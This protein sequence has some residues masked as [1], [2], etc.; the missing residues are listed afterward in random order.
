MT[1]IIEVDARKRVSLGGLATAERYIA[2]VDD[3]GVITL[4]PAVVMTEM[5]ARLLARPDILAAVE[6]SRASAEDAGRPQRRQT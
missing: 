1:V 4:S 6:K 2:D 3:S 5:E